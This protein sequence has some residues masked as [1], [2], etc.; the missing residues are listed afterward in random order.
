MKDNLIYV[1]RKNYEILLIYKQFSLFYIILLI[2]GILSYNKTL[3][4]PCDDPTDVAK[5]E[6][7][8]PDRIQPWF[9]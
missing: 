4:P 7:Q 3:G 1:D 9:L 8:V 5:C 2:I 6:E